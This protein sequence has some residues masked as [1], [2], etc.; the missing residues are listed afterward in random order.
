MLVVFAVVVEVLILDV[1]VDFRPDVEL[2]LMLDVELVVLVLDVELVVL[3]LDVEL[4]VVLLVLL[5]VDEVE[6]VVLVDVTSV[7][8]E[9]V[10]EL[11][12]EAVLVVFE[13]GEYTLM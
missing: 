9:L 12:V 3:V 4:D 6:D 8:D 11:V 13:T 5:P 1:D 10:I 7:D 2:V